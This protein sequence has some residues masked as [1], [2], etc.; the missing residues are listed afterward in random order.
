MKKCRLI[1]RIGEVDEY[2]RFVKVD[3]VGD[4]LSRS[5]EIVGRRVTLHTAIENFVLQKLCC[6]PSDKAVLPGGHSLRGRVAQDEDPRSGAGGRHISDALVAKAQ[7]IRV[8]LVRV[9]QPRT[10]TR[11][12]RL[13][14]EAA[15]GVAGKTKTVRP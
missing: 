1:L 11:A 9:S 8:E 2:N 12:V 15:H 4:Q 7:T 5:I 14:G 6:H 10:D 3:A 13:K